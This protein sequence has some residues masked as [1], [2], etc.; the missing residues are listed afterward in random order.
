MKFRERQK[1]AA[2]AFET[3]EAGRLIEK[4]DEANPETL[5]PL[6]LAYVGDAVFHLYVRKRLLS[7]VQSP[8]DVVSQ[9]GAKIVSAVCQ[10]H[11]YEKIEPMLT[12]EETAIFRR[13]RN[14]HSRTP[15]SATVREYHISTGFEA[16]L[17]MLYLKS[18]TGRLR[19][20][21]EAAFR[22]I[23]EEIANSVE[24][25]KIG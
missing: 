17:G 16:L 19:E 20:I 4:F 18:E 23:A 12:E 24:T 3:D 15:H 2:T 13:G 6:V 11:A 21:L 10:S 9:F 25:K 22:T 7:Y 1:I 14:A 5:P 8:V